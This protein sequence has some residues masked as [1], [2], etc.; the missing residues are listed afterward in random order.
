MVN[1]A[2]EKLVKKGIDLIVGNLADEALGSDTNRVWLVDAAGRTEEVP[3][4][5]K[6]LIAERIVSRAVELE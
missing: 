2:K 1:R 3:T 6:D 4:A 5:S